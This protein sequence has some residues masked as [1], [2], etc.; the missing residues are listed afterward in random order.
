[1]S[2]KSLAFLVAQIIADEGQRRRRGRQK[3][4]R[5]TLRPGALKARL[6]RRWL[7]FRARSDARAA[8]RAR[9]AEIPHVET[10][11]V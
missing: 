8:A 7:E 3:R 9:R 6:E 5:S 2:K 4:R 11:A 10:E 1:M